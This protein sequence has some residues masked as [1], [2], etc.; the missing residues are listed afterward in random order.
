[1]IFQ[2]DFRLSLL[3][4]YTPNEFQ[5]KN[6]KWIFDFLSQQEMGILVSQSSLEPLAT[7]LPFTWKKTDQ[8]DLI[9]EVHLAK[10]N[11]HLDFLKEGK[12]VLFIL[13]GPFA[14]VSS[15]L[16]GHHNVPT[17]NYQAVHL[18]G[19]I[20]VLNEKDTEIHLKELVDR[21][22][23]KR[24]NPLRY[25]DFSREM[26]H[27]YVQELQG[28]RL[29]IYRIEATNKLSQNRNDEDHQA[30]VADLSKS[31]HS[32]AQ[33]IAHEMKSNRSTSH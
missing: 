31:K 6:E 3:V 24:E 9:I 29:H 23:K 22:E 26:I 28:L 30:I 32:N 1:M 2:I 14:Y 25:R 10:A 27:N 20:E 15:S 13:A 12:N 19:T 7:H 11:S 21:H 18:Y 33:Q 17:M 8:S 16:Y 4:M 5:V